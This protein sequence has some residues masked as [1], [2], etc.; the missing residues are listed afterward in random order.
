[1]Y[2]ASREAVPNQ[3]AAAA[4]MVPRAVVLEKDQIITELKE[5]IEILEVKVQKLEALRRLKDQKIQA[6]EKRL[7]QA[8]K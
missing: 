5:T 6:L 7:E 4:E 3:K 1:M 8:T 2:T